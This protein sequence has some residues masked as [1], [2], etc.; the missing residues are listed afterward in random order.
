MAALTNRHSLQVQAQPESSYPGLGLSK[1][2]CLVPSL[3]LEISAP[4][5]SWASRGDLGEGGSLVGRGQRAPLWFN[6]KPRE[7]VQLMAGGPW[8]YLMEAEVPPSPQESPC[9]NS[10]LHKQALSGPTG[11][12][13]STPRVLYLHTRR[14]GC[15]WRCAIKEPTRQPSPGPPGLGS[16]VGMGWGG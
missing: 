12:L 15:P 10:D 8:D 14:E 13:P 9:E 2:C 3:G 16:Q 11:H 6:P 7:T 1:S 5:W 4:G